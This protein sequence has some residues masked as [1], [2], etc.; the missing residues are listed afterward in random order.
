MLTVGLEMSDYCW[1]SHSQKPVG[2]SDII[3]R[4][5]FRD[6]KKVEK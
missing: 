2:S 4:I 5:E 3:S 6:T 1:A